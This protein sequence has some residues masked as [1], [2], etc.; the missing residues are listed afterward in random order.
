MNIVFGRGNSFAEMSC[1]SIAEVM[2]LAPEGSSRELRFPVIGEERDEAGNLVPL[3]GI[4]QM[5]DT[6]WDELT[7]RQVVKNYIKE[8]GK[9]PES[10]QSAFEWQRQWVRKLITE[11]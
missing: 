8:N 9:E 11:M 5:S 1:R 3:L 6:R 10:I 4:K 2:G 7:K